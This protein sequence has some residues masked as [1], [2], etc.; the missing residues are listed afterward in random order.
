MN[1]Q[2]IIEKLVS[3]LM[4]GNEDAADRFLTLYV[5]RHL[6]DKTKQ[7]YEDDLI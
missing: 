2:L 7:A 5:Q 4:E 6:A 3:A 1:K